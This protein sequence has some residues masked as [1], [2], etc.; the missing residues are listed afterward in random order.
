MNF[1]PSPSP[2]QRRPN[3]AADPLALHLALAAFNARRLQPSLPQGDWRD[4]IWNDAEM[5]QA[6]GAWLIEER[7]RQQHRAATAPRDPDGFLC[8]FEDLL[9]SGPGQG[10]SL[11]P[12]LA[13]QATYEEL[14]WFIAQ[15]VSGEAGFEDLVALTQ[16]RFAA[17]EKLELA[18]NYWDE[19]GRGNRKGM[20][21]PM[22]A[23]LA[24][25]LQTAPLLDQ[26]AWEPKALSNLMVGLA[27]NRSYAY[28]SLGA[29]GVIELT[30]PGRAKQVSLGLRRLGV[31]A[32]AR[33]Y[34]DLHATLDV[35]HSRAWN[36]EVFRAVVGACPEAAPA[37]AEGALM[38]LFAGERCF[39]RYRRQ[40]GLP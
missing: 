23:V 29:L 30:A 37:I 38:R 24:H 4:R 35:K 36:D 18:R 13:E 7:A 16:V 12:Y 34:F 14:R 8:W 28:H 1:I 20:H 32:R 10:D 27:A 33:H 17:Q 6:E 2:L 31:S 5:L 3:D 19:M 40:F 11:F 9:T 39:D 22:L 15:E 26:A 21:G 25:E